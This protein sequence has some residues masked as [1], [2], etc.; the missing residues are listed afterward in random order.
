[1]QWRMLQVLREEHRRI[2]DASGLFVT[3]CFC[4]FC[5]TREVVDRSY[6]IQISQL[7]SL[8]CIFDNNPTPTL[9]ISSGRCLLRE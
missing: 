7:C 9:R 5:L 6:S 1:M 8:V 2:N 3:G 4:I